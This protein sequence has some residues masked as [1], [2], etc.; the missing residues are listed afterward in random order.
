M[1]LQQNSG[2]LFF[3]Y[4]FLLLILDLLA[5]SLCEAQKRDFTYVISEESEIG[6]FVGNILLDAGLEGVSSKDDFDIQ[7]YE[8]R[9][10]GLFRA[11]KHTGKLL[12]AQRIDRETICPQKNNVPF[13]MESSNA[14]NFD[15]VVQPED[16][17]CRV[18]LSAYIPPEHWVNIIVV[19]KDIN[20]HAPKFQH[21][22]P[23]SMILGTSK[24]PYV[25]YISEGV[26]IGYQVPLI[27]ATDEDYGINGV[28]TYLLTG[29]DFDK[30]TFAVNYQP[31]YEL[32]LVV[33][34]KLDHEKKTS[35]SGVLTACDG[36]KPTPLC[37]N[38]LLTIFVTD[39]NDNRPVFERALYEVNISENLTVGSV[40]TT[41]RATDQDSGTFGKI[42]Y[43][44]GQIYDQS[45]S[46]YFELDEWT[47]EVRVR[48]P[49]QAKFASRV[50]IPILA[51]DGG[52]IPKVGNTLLQIDVEDV[53]NHAPTL[54]ITPMVTPNSRSLGSTSESSNQVQLWLEENQ[55]VGTQIG[56]IRTG[57]DDV[58]INGD[59]TC[60]LISN[61]TFFLLTHSNSARERKIY[62]LQSNVRFDH[63]QT[64]NPILTADI[65]CSDAGTPPLVTRQGI[66]VNILDV[67]EY[68][69]Y[70]PEDATNYFADISED[71]QP[72]TFVVTVRAVDRDSTAI[73]QF[74]L[75]EE[76][77]KFFRVD[78]LT[79]QIYTIEHLDREQAGEIRFAVRVH[80]GDDVENSSDHSGDG[81]GKISRTANVT[82][83]ITDVNDNSPR[84]EG[85]RHFQVFENRPAYSDM[86][87]Q[88][89]ASDPDAGENGTVNF[90]LV[91]VMPVVNEVPNGTF[92]INPLTGKIYAKVSLDHEMFTQYQL[93]VEVSDTGRPT[94]RKVTE[95]VIIEILD[96]NDNTPL[97]KAPQR[98]HDA[99]S[100]HTITSIAYV[101]K[102]VVDRNRMDYLAFVNVSEAP[103]PQNPLLRLF[104][105]DADSKPNA[106]LSFHLMLIN[107]YAEG[108]AFSQD[109]KLTISETPKQL[110]TSQSVYIDQNTRTLGLIPKAPIK[111]GLQELL[112]RLSDNGNP[113]LHSDVIMFLNLGGRTS[114]HLA[115]LLGDLFRVGSSGN[116]K[117][118]LLLVMSILTICSLFLLLAIC[119]LRR[120]SCTKESGTIMTRN[121]N[122]HMHSEFDDKDS[123]VG[124]GLP[125]VFAVA[126]SNGSSHDNGHADVDGWARG[127]F[128]PTHHWLAS[129]V[130]YSG[131][132]TPQFE[133]SNSIHSPEDN[134]CSSINVM[135]SRDEHVEHTFCHMDARSEADRSN[136][137]QFR[138]CK[139]TGCSGH[140]K[141]SLPVNS[142]AQVSSY[143]CIYS[144]FRRAI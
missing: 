29:K 65:E 94:P 16:A 31:P 68:Q 37:T 12:V 105:S 47:G 135:Q 49:L 25:L 8:D 2:R 108:F 46:D 27:G 122:F 73:M 5:T 26:N 77:Q 79:G 38:Q 23:N 11:D 55:P 13:T 112:L 54:I 34:S 35:Y 14:Q 42:R 86:I 132:G 53:N 51:Q 98:L 7:L 143:M 78:E 124:S 76:A 87:G 18:E 113:P 40:V 136:M 137:P 89:V 30:S 93:R 83:R 67:N 44:I 59:V 52:P 138:F 115:S 57:D 118:V 82:V 128:Y 141:D 24:S 62:S 121:G 39:V 4:F 63:E 32:N 9:T 139:L 90:K 95:T 43:Q 19:V 110:N 120:R 41:V 117:S 125:K 28:Q 101:E 58:G 66:Q 56:I 74:T 3:H 92:E 85:Q 70:F 116:S 81:G 130:H 119:L 104:A 71:V 64:Q 17:I 129:P 88:L 80:D 142:R 36:G 75:S 33:L 109:G 6:T 99:V 96:E 114:S 103:A 50:H 61:Y 45:Q 20:D 22:L 107:Y 10:V 102:G 126:E 123:G 111:H 91:S 144:P 48:I 127:Q 84:L 21:V 100:I 131:L 134:N 15:G 1:P 72:G 69:A 133:M 60:N 106:N 97:W 140:P